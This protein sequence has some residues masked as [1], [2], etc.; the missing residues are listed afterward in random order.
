M[1]RFPNA[2]GCGDLGRFAAEAKGDELDAKASKPVR[3]RLDSRDDELESSDDNDEEP[4][5]GVEL[6]VTFGAGLWLALAQG[7]RFAVEK[8][9]GPFTFEKGELVEAYAINPLC[10]GR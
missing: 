2:D 1:L 10:E 8:I 6:G 7:D 5:T 4:R 3:L 9:L